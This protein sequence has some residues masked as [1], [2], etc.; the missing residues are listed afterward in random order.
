[1]ADHEATL[2]AVGDLMPHPYL[3][4][5]RDSLYRDVGDLIFEADLAMANLE[6]VVLDAPP[7]LVVDFKAG[8]P[9]ALDRAAFDVA[10]GNFGFLAT[11]S[12]HS[13]DFGEPGVESTI[14]AVRAAGI[15]FH[16]INEHEDEAERATV[17]ERNGIRIGIVA[18]TFGTNAHAAPP[19]RPRIVNH[20]KL[21]RTRAE[22]DFAL[23][24]SQLRSCASSKVDF[25]VVQLHWGMEFETY[26]RPEQL[27]VAHHIAELG[28]DAIIGHHPHVLQ[29]VEYYR[30]RRDPDRVVPIYYSL[31]N[32]TNPF[33]HPYM[34][35]S[36]VARL[37]IAKGTQRT[38]VRSAELVEVDQVLDGETIRLRARERSR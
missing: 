26:P 27:E 30:P 29:P 11:A 34:W 5:S 35:R 4:A 31:G 32:L 3:T 24:E 20:T 14:A 18:H 9:I 36:G 19:G 21:N 16:G 22:I 33:E 6:C 37:T 23:L 28:A 38:Y 17:I 8:P 13:L 7:K 12:N 25:V 1:V 10:A 15:A 2:T